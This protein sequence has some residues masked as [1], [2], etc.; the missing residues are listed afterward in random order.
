MRNQDVRVPVERETPDTLNRQQETLAGDICKIS[1]VLYL[2]N[3]HVF[4]TVISQVRIHR[5]DLGIYVRK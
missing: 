3:I 5:Y 2:S 4:G 1:L